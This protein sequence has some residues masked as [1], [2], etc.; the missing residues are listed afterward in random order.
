MLIPSLLL[1]KRQAMGPNPWIVRSERIYFRIARSRGRSAEGQGD[2]EAEEKTYPLA[3]IPGRPH[4]PFHGTQYAG[5]SCSV[6]PGWK[7]HRAWHHADDSCADCHVREPC[8]LHVRFPFPLQG[9][10]N[11]DALVALGSG[12]SFLWSLSVLYK[13]TYFAM[14][15]NRLICF[16]AGS[17]T[18]S[19]RP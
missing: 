13:M 2:A 14:Q 19:L 4:V 6:L 18:L 9:A 1:S 8:I 15:G 12:V 10:P 5:I 16:T 3:R 7:L 17:F 11:M